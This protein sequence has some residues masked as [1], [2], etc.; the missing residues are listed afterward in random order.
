MALSSPAWVGAEHRVRQ[1][2][3]Q[4]AGEVSGQR[5]LWQQVAQS[6]VV[7]SWNKHKAAVGLQEHT[8]EKPHAMSAFADITINTYDMCGC[9]AV[10]SIAVP[11]GTLIG[12]L[13][14]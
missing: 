3:L 6:R 12:T 5:R 8:A 2:C 4:L 13:P 10:Y 14:C 7:W 11:R 9:Y 1:H